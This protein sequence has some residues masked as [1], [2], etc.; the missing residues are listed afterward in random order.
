M[1]FTFKSNSP[2]LISSFKQFSGTKQNVSQSSDFTLVDLNNDG[3]NEVVYTTFDHSWVALENSYLHIFQYKTNKWT[4][5]TSSLL[6]D[7]E[8]SGISFVYIGDFNHDG[9]KDIFAPAQTDAFIYPPMDLFLSSSSE[10]YTK[11]TY[12]Y[13]S[14]FTG[15]YVS[16]V[17]H[18]GFDDVLISTYGTD[19]GIAFGGPL[20]LTFI[21]LLDSAKPP[22]NAPPWGGSAI[23]AADFLNNG[24][25]TIIIVDDKSTF[26]NSTNLYSWNLDANDN[27][28]FS[29]ISTLPTPRFELDKWKSYSFGGDTEL[30]GVSHD[31]SATPFDFS[32]DGLIDVIITSRPWLTDGNWPVYSEVQFLLNKGNGVFEDVTDSKLVGYNNAIGASYQP[33]LI[34]ANGDGRTDIF[35]SSN[36]NLNSLSSSSTSLLIQQPDGTFVDMGRDI[37]SKIWVDS[38]NQ[39]KKLTSNWIYTD[40]PNTL[41]LTKGADGNLYVF[42]DVISMDSNGQNVVNVFSTK[43]TLSEIGSSGDDNFIGTLSNDFMMGGLGD[44]T[45]YVDAAKDKVTEKSNQGIDTVISSISYTLGTNVENLTLSGT[46]GLS[47]KGNTAANVIIGSSGNDT[48]NGGLGN[49]TLTGGLGNDTF[50]FNTRLGPTNIDTIIDFTNGDKIALA[51]SIFSKLKGDKDLSDNL[52]VQTIVGIS[53]QDTN[54]YLFYDLESGRLY[55]DADGSGA[56]AAVQVAI[57][58]TGGITLTANDFSIV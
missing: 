58:G 22:N 48:I 24:T 9:K 27:L 30:F 21:P 11:I 57:I 25:Q 10:K 8:I 47:G 56:K 54:D 55:Y 41:Q 20:G 2:T 26:L 6:A 33:I 49:D 40:W 37:F 39:V 29:L 28:S 36:D 35:L 18:D 12:E 13:N 50:V 19:D 15:G 1:A 46:S 52:Y 3:L 17:N 32:N 53:T 7:N 38:V 4:D 34:D 23:C 51:G 45:Y 42:S 31:I 43:L 16:D 5:V 44:D 14:W